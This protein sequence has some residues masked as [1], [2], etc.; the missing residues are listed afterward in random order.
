M[1]ARFSD[2]ICDI[3][4][5]PLP[6]Y[7]YWLKN[8]RRIGIGVMGW[9]SALYMLKIRFSSAEAL[10]LIYKLPSVYHS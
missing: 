4:Y 5:V 6:E 7:E 3:S 9:G 8:L 2:N 1:V 10:C